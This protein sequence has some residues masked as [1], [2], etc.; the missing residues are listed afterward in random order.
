[1]KTTEKPVPSVNKKTGAKASKASKSSGDS[2][3]PQASSR[4][5][6]KKMASKLL[7]STEAIDLVGLL[8]ALNQ[9]PMPS[10]DDDWA[11]TY[12][13][14]PIQNHSAEEFIEFFFAYTLGSFSE[15]EEQLNPGDCM[16]HALRLVAFYQI[17]DA[18]PAIIELVITVGP[19]DLLEAEVLNQSL[20][21]L[22]PYILEPIEKAIDDGVAFD[23]DIYPVLLF[24]ETL[25]EGSKQDPDLRKKVLEIHRKLLKDYKL[26]PCEL[27]SHIVCHLAQFKDDKSLPLIR[28]VFREDFVSESVATWDDI[29]YFSEYHWD[30]SRPKTVDQGSSLS[31]A[32]YI[33]DVAFGHL[34][35]TLGCDI[36]LDELKCL[37]LGSILSLGPAQPLSLLDTIMLDDEGEEIEFETQGQF[38]FFVSQLMGLWNLMADYQG[39]N[40]PLPQVQVRQRE[41]SLDPVEQE[42]Y[43]E[44]EG[45]ILSS[46]MIRVMSLVDYFLQGFMED[47][48]DDHF[49]PL[50]DQFISGLEDYLSRGRSLLGALKEGDQEPPLK[51][52][53]LWM[54]EIYP[55][56]KSQYLPFAK[57]CVRT[58]HL[59]LEQMDKERPA[60]RLKE[61]LVGRNE[62]CPCGSGKK[63]KKCCL[64]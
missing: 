19:D 55:F 59:A 44:F 27:N 53:S 8:Q 38:Q 47:A 54:D 14:F 64:H 6:Q 30:E 49:I 4:A 3:A 42:M 40:F 15:D 26:L 52:V 61:V 32:D 57:S 45:L 29:L 2:I 41:E 58:R 31:D 39:K 23:P 22:G 13:D 46:R 36:N 60:P 35:R 24:L 33:G 34:L 11:Q 18:V 43:N 7:S 12:S 25:T 10:L 28:K 1:V 51:E 9:L 5:P 16:I 21:Q 62:P 50:G 56:W 17:Q 37:I 48:P 20:S 63:F